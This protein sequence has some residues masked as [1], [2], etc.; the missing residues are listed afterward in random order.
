MTPTLH[1]RLNQAINQWVDFTEVAPREYG[2]F[3]WGEYE[4]Q[5]TYREL[6]EAQDLDPTGLTTAM[7]LHTFVDA[8][9]RNTTLSMYELLYNREE[10]H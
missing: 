7:L 2:S 10:S 4:V 1:S 5:G 6:N 3:S 8:M 9:A